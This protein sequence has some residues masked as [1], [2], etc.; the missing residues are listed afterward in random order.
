MLAVR[1]PAVAPPAEMVGLS[2][3]TGNLSSGLMNVI[4]L[5]DELVFSEIITSI[6]ASLYDRITSP[7][8]GAFIISAL[9]INYKTLFLLFDSQNYYLKINYLETVLYPSTWHFISKLFLFPSLSA[10]LF[11]LVYPF[12]ARLA[13]QFWLGQQKQLKN[14]KVK[15]EAETPL[16]IQESRELRRQLAVLEDRFNTELREKEAEIDALKKD[17]VSIEKEKEDLRQD[18]VQMYNVELEDVASKNTVPVNAE[19]PAPGEENELDILVKKIDTEENIAA[20]FKAFESVGSNPIN[21]VYLPSQAGLSS[22]R[23]EAIAEDLVSLGLGSITLGNDD[24]QY[25][26]LTSEGK[27]FALRHGYA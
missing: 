3:E 17:I 22:I 11:I 20:F 21:L 14:I 10:I 2:G 13:Y 26:R 8:S 9:L 19:T 25:F 24:T 4:E 6:K 15:V 7:L 27:R 16:T 12:P 18:L 1:C 23:T 5:K